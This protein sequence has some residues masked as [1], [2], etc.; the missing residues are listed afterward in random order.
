M[1]LVADS[2]SQKYNDRLVL[3]E[4]TFEFQPN[5]IYGLIG[6][7][8]AG[9]STLLLL[10]SAMRRPF[11]GRVFYNGKPLEHSI[12][13]ISCVWQRPYLF[14]G[15]VIDNIGYGLRIRRWD[16]KAEKER[17]KQLLK[18]F[19]LEDLSRQ[20]ASKL[21]GGETAR[22]V[23]A[24][25]IAAR[26]KILLLDEPAANLDPSNTRLVEEVL[27]RIHQEEGITI[28][29]VTHDMFQAKRLADITLYLSGGRLIEYGCSKTIFQAPS[30][31]ETLRFIRGEL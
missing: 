12:P 7:N 9:K 2:L 19:K 4:F 6:P 14:Q 29:L 28:I 30:S 3:Q 11:S 16:R 5:K 25:A 15:N 13:E 10:L 27:S 26:P 8:G 20:R 23:I 18:V 31:H 17:I 1:V 22:V 24:R 21:S